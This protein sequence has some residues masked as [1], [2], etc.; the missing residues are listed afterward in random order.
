VSGQGYSGVGEVLPETG[1]PIG[2][3]TWEGLRRLGMVG[4]V[5]N[6]SQLMCE[7]GEWS[8]HGD[9]V[10]VALLALGYKLALD[11]PG[12]K[13]SITICGLI[14]FESERRFAATFY[15]ESNVTKVAVKGATEE[16]LLRCDGMVTDQGKVPIE[17]DRIDKETML[18]AAQGYRPW[19]RRRC[20]FRQNMKFSRNIIFRR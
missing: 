7:R 3:E 19:R 4:V 12:L 15:R 20:P 16:V 5:C 9:A 18:L 1:E 11:P 14:P 17:V 2:L 10:D 13:K 8:H 6:E